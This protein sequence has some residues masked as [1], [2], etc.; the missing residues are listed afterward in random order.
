M[1][2]FESEVNCGKHLN[3]VETTFNNTQIYETMLKTVLVKASET[4]VL[5]GDWGYMS[6]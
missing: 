6:P 1:T 5:I 3:N 2:L 4:N